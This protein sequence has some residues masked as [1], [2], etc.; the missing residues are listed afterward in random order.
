MAEKPADKPATDHT[1][2]KAKKKDTLVIRL[3]ADYWDATGT[4]QSASYTDENG[5][6]H[7]TGRMLELP[8]EEARKIVKT[9]AAER[10]DE[11]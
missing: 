9:S 10:G 4:R 6:F 8:A 2:D 1:D 3:L 5:E 7:A 11:Y